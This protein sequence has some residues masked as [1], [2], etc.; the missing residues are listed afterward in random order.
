MADTKDQFYD[1]SSSGTDDTPTQVVPAG[2]TSISPDND[3][4]KAEPLK[5]FGSDAPD[6]GATAWLVVAGTWCT[7]FC[8]FGWLNSRHALDTD[9]NF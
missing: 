3:Q 8:S 1:P 9:I 6:G 2:S 5:N 4:E 7:L